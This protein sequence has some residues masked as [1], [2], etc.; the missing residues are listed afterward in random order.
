MLVLTIL[1]VLGAIR[2]VGVHDP[3]R[4]LVLHEPDYEN[5]ESNKEQEPT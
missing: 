5:D 3:R 4:R 2:T 1:G